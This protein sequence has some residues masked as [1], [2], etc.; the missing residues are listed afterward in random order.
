VLSNSPDALVSYGWNDRVLA[1][2][3]NCVA[4]HTGGVIDAPDA[5]PARVVRIERSAC[6]AIGPDGTDLMLASH[7]LPVV[8]DWVVAVPGSVRQ[9]LPRWSML[10]RLDADGDSVQTIASNI[11][12]VAIVSP[13]DRSSPARVERELALAWDSGAV[14]LV[15][16]TKT[17]LDSE[18]VVD[19]LTERLVGVDVIPVCAT[20]H[21][22]IEALTARLQPDRTAVLLGPSGA[23][24]STL[25]N[26]LLG[27]DRL[28]TGAVR[29]DDGR[30]RHTTTSRQMVSIPGGG[31][32]IDTPGL[33][34]LGLGGDIDV[35]IGFADIREFASRCRFS[36][37]RHEDE[38]GCAVTAAVATGK[39]DPD[40]L[41]S[42]RKLAREAAWEQRRHDPLLRREERQLWRQR[43]REVRAK[44]NRR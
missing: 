44:R 40:R 19:R 10:T 42:F 12:I 21:V 26:A 35:S 41:A 14:P 4:T 34:S 38:P 20:G 24:K 43:T 27:T 9:I 11:D 1:L 30:G 25:A 18:G 5:F 13:A 33:R 23:G 28:A 8:G 7:P 39:L 2:Y 15:V 6:F 3:N 32:L 31:V 37:C 29:D 22:G 36:D 16:V 17:D